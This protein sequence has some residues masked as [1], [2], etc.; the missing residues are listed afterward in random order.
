MNVL[1]IE[2]NHLG[3]RLNNAGLVLE[4]IQHLPGVNAFFA[5]SQDALGT[6]E[7][8]TWIGPRMLIG[9]ARL[10]DTLTNVSGTGT[11]REVSKQVFELRAIIKSHAIDHVLIPS[12]DGLCQIAAAMRPFASLKCRAGV[13]IEAMMLRGRFAYESADSLKSKL[14]R[15]AWFAAVGHSPIDLIHH[16]DPMIYRAAIE[17]KPSLRSRLKSIPDP[18]DPIEAD[19]DRLTARRRLGIPE[20]GRLMGCV[21][22]IE[23]RK[24]MDLLIRAFAH[25]IRSGKLSAESDRLLL[26]GKH[27]PPIPK[28]LDAEASDLVKKGVIISIA[29]FVSDVEMS[30]AINAMNLVVTPYPLHIGSASIVIRAAAQRR[31]VLASDFGWL[32][33]I[34]PE[35]RLGSVCDVND[36]AQFAQAMPRALDEAQGFVQSEMAERFVQY[37]AVANFQAHWV[38]RICQRLNVTPPPILRWSDLESGNDRAEA[39]P[40]AVTCQ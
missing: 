7:F 3:H 6:T 17:R 28:I 16:M 4:A 39:H 36:V 34:V 38:Q 22:V 14:A 20:D 35:F 30:N 24:G 23:V 31:P 13:E 11:R 25:N 15:S 21:G 26:V 37:S 18:V 5:T 27:E 9:S 12:G 1:V 19:L 32:G 8:K 10:I 29:R 40:R 2:A 33:R